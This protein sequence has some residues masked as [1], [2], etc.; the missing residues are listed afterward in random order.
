MF[1]K[2]AAAGVGQG[3]IRFGGIEGDSGQ[4]SQVAVAAERSSPEVRGGGFLATAPECLAEIWVAH[5]H[6][7]ADPSTAV[8]VVASLFLRL[9]V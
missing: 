2:L 6:E 4:R 3:T 8:A 7:L 1:K 5:R 9:G